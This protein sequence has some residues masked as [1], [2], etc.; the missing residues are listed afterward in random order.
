MNATPI[1]Y[2]VRPG[3]EAYLAPAAATRGIVLPEPGEGLIEGLAVPE[4]EALDAIAAQ[5]VAARRPT[6]FPGPLVLWASAPKG[7]AKAAALL[8]LVAAVPGMR[9]I[10][11]PDYRPKYPR[12]HPDREINPNHPNLTIWHNEIDVCLF[13]GVHCHYANIALKIIRAG[14]SCYTIALCGERGHEDAMITLRDADAAVIGRLT[15]AVARAQR[16]AVHG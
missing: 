2:R 4:A 8:E 7:L 6:L 9:M 16:G 1:P 14:S 12:I 11:M 3:P 5:L 13:A 15:E 10:P